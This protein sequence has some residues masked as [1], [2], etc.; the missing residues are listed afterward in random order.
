MV[1]ALATLHLHALL[2]PLLY[3]EDKDTSGESGGEFI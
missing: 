2:L 3:L 1:D